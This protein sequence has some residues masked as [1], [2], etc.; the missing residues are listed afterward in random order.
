[1]NLLKSFLKN[2]DQQLGAMI[3]DA[4]VDTQR[5]QYQVPR[6]EKDDSRLYR[7]GKF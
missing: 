6:L 1:M 2:V 7:R 3:I 5:V 4:Y